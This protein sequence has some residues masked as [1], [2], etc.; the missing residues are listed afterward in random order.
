MTE[1]VQHANKTAPTVDRVP[2]KPW[3]SAEILQLMDD[4]K[5]VKGRDDVRHAEQDHQI[6]RSCQK[7]KERFFEDDCAAIEQLHLENKTKN[8]H[9][10]I[11]ILTGKNRKSSHRGNIKNLDGDLIFEQEEVLKRWNEY[12]G[13]LFDDDRPEQPVIENPDGP[14]ILQ[15]E[16]RL[17]LKQT[18]VGK[19]VGKDGISTEMWK[20][21]GDFAVEK[22][23][24]LF[25]RIYSSGYI[26]S[27]MS[28]SVFIT[29]P[30]K[31]KATECGEYRLISL[32][33]HITK[34]FLRVILN[35]IKTRI[36]IEVGEEQFGFRAGSGTR[37][38]IFCL[39]IL[40]QKH[41][42]VN[43]DL[44][45]CFIDYAKAFDRVKHCELIECLKSIGIDGKDCRIISNLYWHQQAAI[46]VGEDISEYTPIQR[47]VR[48]GC[49]LS[50]LLFNLYTE[51][52][53]REFEGMKGV[54]AGGRII[55]NLRYA[56]DTALLADNS[57]DP[58]QLVTAVKEGSEEKG[59]NM[60]VRKTKTMVMSRG[61][62][63]Q[64]D[65]TADNEILEQLNLMKYLGQSMTPDGRSDKEIQIRIAIAKSRFEAMSKLFTSKQLSIDLRLRMLNCYI[66]SVL[67]YGC[68][69]WTINKTMQNKLE[70]CE[71]WFLRRMGK[72]SWTQKLT[73]EKV[74]SMLNTKRQLLYNIKRRKMCFFGHIK[75]HNTL[76]KQVLEGKIEGKRGRGRPRL[77]WTDNIRQWAGCDMAE[78]TRLARDRKQ[79]QRISRLPLKRDGT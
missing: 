54:S 51:L 27:E 13:E 32:M 34:I 46:R 24:H 75:R 73:N 78:C 47:G 42:E 11:K 33:P 65:I 43:K 58:Q 26:P 55:N 60:N 22:L 52:I 4:R 57:H 19:A 18:S 28:K 63:V 37:E 2:K 3:I 9:R 77:A 53:F 29:L 30:K 56:D 71:M 31:S 20:V 25:N 69:T 1:S 21:L 15:S 8:L 59:L 72:I 35:R 5:A 10:E 40:A 23:T 67:L 41:I 39:N 74:L 61:D 76:V 66:Y 50:P 49:V 64:T 79:W 68:E 6:K 7:A 36:N 17:A 62:D 16:V 12:I 14:P 38:G 48:Q 70:A 44:Y 45:V